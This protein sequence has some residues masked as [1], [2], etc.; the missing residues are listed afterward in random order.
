[1]YEELMERLVEQ[2]NATAARPKGQGL[3]GGH[4][5]HQIL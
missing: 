5:H 2:D 1:M 3:G 4:G